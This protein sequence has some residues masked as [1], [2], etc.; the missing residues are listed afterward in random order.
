[1]PRPCSFKFCAICVNFEALVFVWELRFVETVPKRGF[2]NE[3]FRFRVN[4]KA[5]VERANS[6]GKVDIECCT[7][8]H[9]RLDLEEIDETWYSSTNILLFKGIKKVS[10]SNYFRVARSHLNKRFLNLNHILLRIGVIRRN[11]ELLQSW[12]SLSCFLLS[13]LVI[14]YFWSLSLCLFDEWEMGRERQDISVTES[15]GTSLR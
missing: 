10:S 14:L 11:Y 13:R 3:V 4:D 6:S 9:D 12:F 8:N 2:G 15:D 1:M 7:E 5:S